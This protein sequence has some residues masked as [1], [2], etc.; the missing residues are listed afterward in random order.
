MLLKYIQFNVNL[1]VFVKIFFVL[2]KPNWDMNFCRALA[3]F[4][5]AITRQPASQFTAV[6][7]TQPSDRPV[8]A[9][10]WTRQR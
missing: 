4:C 2:F 7:L 3:Y 8:V 9:S 6:V 1:N 5:R 10:T